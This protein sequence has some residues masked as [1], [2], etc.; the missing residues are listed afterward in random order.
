MQPEL[1][2]KLSQSKVVTEA[3]LRS[4]V[5]LISDRL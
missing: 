4:G 2:N 5:L 1:Y 3:A